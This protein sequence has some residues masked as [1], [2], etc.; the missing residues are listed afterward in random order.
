MAHQALHG[1]KV[2]V[3]DDLLGEGRAVAGAAAFTEG[4][5]T[6]AE[7]ARVTGVAG[8]ILRGDGAVGASI[9]GTLGNVAGGSPT[10]W[11]LIRTG[12]DRLG[13]G[14]QRRDRRCG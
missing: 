14:H 11:L 4:G 10:T 9:N 2:T 13:R 5:A 7:G 6:V 12:S 3:G 1:Q 8:R